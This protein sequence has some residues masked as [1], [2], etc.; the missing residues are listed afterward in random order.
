MLTGLVSQLTLHLSD[1]TLWA[2]H[3][4]IPP[5]DKVEY[6]GGTV[7][8]YGLLFMIILSYLVTSPVFLF[9]WHW[10][11]MTFCAILPKIPP[12]DNVDYCGVNIDL[13]GFLF[14][15]SFLKD[16]SLFTYLEAYSAAFTPSSGL[17]LCPARPSK[18]VVYS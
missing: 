14:I 3:P 10:S 16:I 12:L 11:A 2:I 6:G 13:S 8:L 4:K 7:K 9:T 15:R 17:E 18:K 5:I 1:I